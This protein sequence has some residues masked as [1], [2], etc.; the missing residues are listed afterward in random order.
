MR[1]LHLSDWHIGR[2]FHEYP[3]LGHAQ[4]V[5]GAVPQ[6]IRQH[7]IDVVLVAGDVYDV[8][9]P[10]AEAVKVFQQVTQDILMAGAQVIMTSGNHD[11]APRLGVIGA[12]SAASGLHVLADPSALAT[13][14]PLGDQYGPV[15]VYGLPYLQPELVR[16]QS[17]APDDASTQHDVIAAAMRAVRA[18][19]ASQASSGR[20]SVVV[21]HTFV[22]GA[23]DEP[24]AERS[25]MK[26]RAAGGIDAVPPEV[27]D[28]VDYVALGHIHTGARLTP[29]MAYSGAVL[30]HS[31]K[32]AG[33]PRGGWLVDLGPKGVQ[34]IEWIDLPVPRQLTQIEGRLE[35]LLG[36]PA[37]QPFSD[38]FIRAVYTDK[39]RQAEPMQKLKARFPWCAEVVHQPVGA[40]PQ[41]PA[42]Y[43]DR[44]KGKSDRDVIGSFLA[45]VRDGDGASVDEARIISEV[46]AEVETGATR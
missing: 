23:P 9:N 32:E 15:D 4:M 33:Q 6:L 16:G 36:D 3:T 46:I 44:V 22:A 25:I 27:F 29:N 26:G 35:N 30:H 20:R 7:G 39:L 31:F 2:V 18:T 17:W 14:V 45:D 42:Y 40:V 5:L 11:S 13:P 37:W 43:R 12:F 8:A 19:V 1:L 24:F 10:S 34:T 21:A 38:H 41:S 28:G